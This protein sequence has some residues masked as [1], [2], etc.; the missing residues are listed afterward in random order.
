MKI[1][2]SLDFALRVLM[3]LAM[4]KEV[5]SMPQISRAMGVPY[6]NLTKLVQRMARAELI[7]TLK[8]KSGGVCLLKAPEDIT[9]RNVIDVI[10][11]PTRL[12]ECLMDERVCGMVCS[13]KLRNKFTEIQDGIN[14][15]LDGVNIK[16][17]I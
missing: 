4:K 13:C 15:I 1:S 8:G 11:G 3:Y 9:I 12:V 17:L 7:R 2:R 14:N 5:V 16:E 10:D 6:H